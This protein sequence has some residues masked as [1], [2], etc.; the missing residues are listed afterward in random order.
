[1]CVQYAIILIVVFLAQIALI[2]FAA[3]FSEKVRIRFQI[4][5]IQAFE[6]CFITLFRGCRSY[7]LNYSLHAVSREVEAHR[8]FVF[9]GDRL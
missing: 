2:I 8:E 9:L 6:H 3:V 1:M 7:A 5:T 4:F